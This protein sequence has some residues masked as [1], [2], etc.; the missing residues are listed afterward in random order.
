MIRRTAS[1]AFLLRDGF[2]G[3]V[4]TGGPATRC[5][6]DGR[7]LRQPIWKKDGYLVLVDLAPGEHVL[8]LSRNGYRDEELTIP[9][10]D[11]ATVEDTISLKPGAGYRFPRGTVRVSLTV[12]RGK[13]DVG[14]E[15]LW[16]GLR[17][18]TRLKLAQEKAEAGDAQ[19]R[20]FCDGSAAQLPI[21]GHFLINDTKAPELVYL[22]SL[23]NEAGEFSPPLTLPHSRGTELFPVQPYQTDESGMVQ[24]LVREPGT[25]LGFCGGAVFSAELSAGDQNLEWRLED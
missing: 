5:L 17:P 1:A 25:L 8:R 15:R 7:P 11:G 23:V 4:L 21:P 16:L 13:K 2:T 24:L 14:G 18:R 20:L 19:A 12:V 10:R 9:V 22:R 3:A 6:L